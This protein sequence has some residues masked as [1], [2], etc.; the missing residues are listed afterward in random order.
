[1]KALSTLNGDISWQP[2]YG[3]TNMSEHKD[4]EPWLVELREKARDSGTDLYEDKYHYHTYFMRGWLPEGVIDD[5][6]NQTHQV[7]PLTREELAFQRF[8]D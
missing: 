5:I 6:R 2:T 7:A 4:Y 3:E 1:M 8:A